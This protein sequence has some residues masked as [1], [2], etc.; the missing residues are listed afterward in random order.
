MAS[1]GFVADFKKFLMQ[2]NVVDLAVAVVIG[3]AFGKVV[4]SLVE[5]IVM[6]IVTMVI[7]GGDWKN[8]GIVL[9]KMADPKDPTK[10]IDNIWKFGS[11]AAAILD[12]VIIALAIFTIIRMLEGMKKRFA[13]Q[14]AMAAVDAPAPEA[15]LQ[16]RMANTLDRLADVLEKR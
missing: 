8:A 15:V 16:E 12:F 5:N 10:T 7:P 6:P 2:G 3:G 4:T 1:S 9:G 11:F 14:E 13:R